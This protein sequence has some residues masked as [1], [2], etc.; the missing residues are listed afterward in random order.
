LEKK[1][2]PEKDE[3]RK[4]NELKKEKDRY[5]CQDPG[6]GIEEKI[7]SH[8]SRNC[9]TGSYG[10]DFGIPVSEEMNQASGHTTKNIEDKISNVTKPILYIIPED[11]KKPH[12]P[13]NMKES[14]VE[15][16]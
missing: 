16:H 11:I 13:Q 6:T 5:Q 7:S 10:R 14:S 3:G 4:L 9:S 12:V 2:I 1:P 15:K 8:N